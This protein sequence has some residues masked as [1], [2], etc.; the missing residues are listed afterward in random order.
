MRVDDILMASGTVQ[1]VAQLDLGG[2]RSLAIWQNSHDAKSYKATDGHVFSY[3]LKGG[4]GT[5]RVDGMEKSGWAGAL[6][7]MP[8][9]HSSEWDITDPMQFVHLYVPDAELR[10]GFARVHDCD[11]RRM[12]MDERT[13]EDAGDLGAPMQG[14]AAA[15]M[16]G[17]VLAADA[18][19]AQFLAA[20][21]GKAV[22]V[23]GGLTARVLSRVDEWIAAHLD[24]DI[25][26]ADLA[27]LG[28]LSEFHFQ[29]M[30]KT[31]RGVSPH[32]WVMARRVEAA[33]IMLETQ[34]L[35]DVAA[36]C[37]FAN[38]SHFTRRFKAQVGVTPGAYRRAVIDQ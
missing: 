7:V 35:A 1:R 8:E 20:M 38:Q 12:D 13:Y 10:A 32:A 23:S 26:L 6:C 24:Q 19:Y 27:A 16:A 17:D 21:P 3:Y 37:G 14:L 15:A 4:D 25:R 30:F 2:S 31:S 22:Q 5:R 11:A 28:D 33:R 34:S 29:R 18:V 36:A 9:D